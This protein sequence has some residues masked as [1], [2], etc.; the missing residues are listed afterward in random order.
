VRTL[1]EVYHCD[2]AAVD[3]FG[4]SPFHTACAYQQVKI[5]AYLCRK[6]RSIGHHAF[7]PSAH[8][9]YSGDTVL[10]AACK[11]GS[12]RIVRFLIYEF[13]I[14][15]SMKELMWKFRS[16]VYQEDIFFLLGSFH[17]LNLKIDIMSLVNSYGHTPLQLACEH[18]HIEIV[19]FFFTEVKTC[20]ISLDFLKC[21]PSLLNTA[22]KYKHQ[23]VIDFLY[24][25]CDVNT[26]INMSQ[27]MFT[28]KC[29]PQCGFGHFELEGESSIFGC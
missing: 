25:H 17:P 19:K 18:G 24:N 3:R 23:K 11:S 2:L 10:H 28:G 26:P 22:F 4:N 7:N 15:P 5:V 1:V 14:D 21:I 27:P 12:V 20:I 13:F 29:L 8:T 9:N 6:V 16:Y